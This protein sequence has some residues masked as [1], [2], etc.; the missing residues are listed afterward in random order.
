MADKLFLDFNGFH[1]DCLKLGKKILDSGYVPDMLVGIWRG[2]APVAVSV[3]QYLEYHGHKI[4]HM[5]I[6]T[7]AYAGVDKMKKDV[8][9][10]GLG[11]IYEN[12]NKD[13]KLLLVDD[14][15]DTGKSVKKIISI[16]REHMGDNAPK[17]IKI[18]TVYFKPKRNKT[19]LLPDFYIYRTDRWIV[20]PSE[21]EDLSKEDIKNKFHGVYD[22]FNFSE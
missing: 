5:P 9:V 14:V 2:G 13:T 7:S 12:T 17:D 8:K 16:I 19:K 18:A 20:F 4:D 1:I 15:F 10:W 11:Y 3:H 22:L 6:K 21:F